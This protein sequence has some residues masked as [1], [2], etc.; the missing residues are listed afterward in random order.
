MR[1]EKNI[2]DNGERLKT[3]PQRMTVNGADYVASELTATHHVVDF[4][5]LFGGYGL[6]PLAPGK[7]SP[8]HPRRENSSAIT[9]SAASVTR[10]PPSTARGR[11][12]SGS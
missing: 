3:I 10:W 7:R 2:E 8:M 6:K 12:R 11:A 4:T 5:A 9:M 1:K